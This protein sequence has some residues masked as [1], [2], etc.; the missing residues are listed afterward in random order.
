MVGDNHDPFKEGQEHIERM[1]TGSARE[2]QGARRVP[3]PL[4][5]CRRA[6]NPIEMRSLGRTLRRWKH[7]IAAWHSAQV[8]NGPTEAVNNLIKS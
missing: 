7:Q 5:S 6:D 8:T 2:V 4:W 1:V 3:V